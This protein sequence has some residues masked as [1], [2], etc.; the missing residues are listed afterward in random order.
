VEDIDELEAD[1][2][3]AVGRPEMFA[4]FQPQIDLGTGSVVAVEGL[5]RWRHPEHGM[6]APDLFIPLAERSG[7]I[8]ELGAFMVDECVAAAEIWRDDGQSVEVSVNV[9]PLQLEELAFWDH[10]TDRLHDQDLV[11]SALTLEITESMPLV[12][13]EVVVPRL[14]ALRSRGLGVALDDFGT[15]H[16]S[17]D[18]LDLLPVTEVKLDRSLIHAHVVGV[19]DGLAGI[20]VLARARGLRVVAEGIETPAHL[21]LARSLGCDRAQGF[22]LGMPMARSDVDLLLA[23]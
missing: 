4:V 14:G 10:L 3:L 11:P 17:A 6:I 8:H 12:I 5:C 16:A 7:I 18:Q 1:L 21:E 2:R 23:A 22:M 13:P 9:S 19:P 15:G 20:M